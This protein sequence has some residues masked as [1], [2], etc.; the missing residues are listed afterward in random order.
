MFAEYST[1]TDHSPV[2]ENLSVKAGMDP[3]DLAGGG[4]G[5][6]G[7]GGLVCTVLKIFHSSACGNLLL[8][9]FC[10]SRIACTKVA[11]IIHY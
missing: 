2:K 5:G 9:N 7:G 11:R 8:Q 6:G 10:R 3:R 4:G 1:V